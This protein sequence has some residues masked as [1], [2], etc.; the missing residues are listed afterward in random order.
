MHD[1]IENTFIMYE[2]WLDSTE[3]EE[4]LQNIDNVQQNFREKPGKLCQPT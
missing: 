4:K 2:F 1:Y 3:S